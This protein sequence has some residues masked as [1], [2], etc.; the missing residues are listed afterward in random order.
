MDRIL[1]ILKSIRDDVDYENETALVDDGIFDSFDIVGLVGELKE[2]YDID[3]N[4]EDLTPENFNSV[5]AIYD[6]VERILND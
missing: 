3:I 2:E 4:I 5:Q 1:E 6:L